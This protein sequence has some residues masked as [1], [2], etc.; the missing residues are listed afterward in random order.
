MQTA[1]KGAHLKCL[2]GRAIKC[3]A[4]VNNPGQSTQKKILIFGLLLLFEYAGLPLRTQVPRK[5]SPDIEA[6]QLNKHRTDYVNPTLRFT[7]GEIQLL[8]KGLKY[9]LHCKN[10]K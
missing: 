3:R 5:Q 4:P 10:K 7:R 1:F 2:A 6:R 8:N 9:N